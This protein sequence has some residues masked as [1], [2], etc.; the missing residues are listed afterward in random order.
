MSIW[1]TIVLQATQPLPGADVFD[2]PTSDKPEDLKGLSATTGCK[3]DG[4]SGSIV[5]CGRRQDSYRLPLPKI[6]KPV[7]PSSASQRLDAMNIGRAGACSTAGSA[8][9]AN[10]SV[11]EWA[12]IRGEK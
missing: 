2:L 11:E 1:L 12:R 9:V 10:C 7:G 4:L 3:R 8:G 6:A 5:V